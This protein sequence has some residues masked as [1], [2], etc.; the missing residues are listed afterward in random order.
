MYFAKTNSKHF[1]SA[2]TYANK[3][4]SRPSKR[5]G[6]AL[7]L[8]TPIPAHRIPAVRAPNKDLN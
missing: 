5:G 3:T 1:K 6:V 4:R 2:K 7:S 8:P